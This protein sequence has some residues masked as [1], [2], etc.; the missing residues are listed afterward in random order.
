MPNPKKSRVRHW[1]KAIH[2]AVDCL[3]HDLLARVV[4]LPGRC[5]SG[6]KGDECG[7]RRKHPQNG[8]VLFPRTR[9]VSLRKVGTRVKIARTLC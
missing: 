6:A 9:V 8:S 4:L 2:L 3:A 7:H 1:L 5:R